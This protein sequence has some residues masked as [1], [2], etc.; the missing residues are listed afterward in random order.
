MATIRTAIAL[1]DGVTSP[2]HSMQ[3]AMNIVL[4]SFEAMQRASSNAVD[5]SAIQEARDELARAETAFDSIEQSIRDADNQQQKFNSSIRA[6]S[7]A[8]DGLWNKLKGIAATVGGLTAL[9]KLV[10]LSDSM[11]STKA[12]LN[13]IVDDGGSV[14]DLEKKIMASAQRSRASY[15]ST[16]KA[17][18]QMGLMAGDAF[19]NNDELIAF[20]ET[21]NK[22]FVIAG[23]NAAGAE[24]AT[25]QLTQAMASGVLRGEE[26]NSVFEQAPNVIQSIADYLDVP[27]GQIRTM[28]SEGQITADIVKNAMISATDEVNAKFESMPL[29]WGQV[30]TQAGNIALQVLQPL[31]NGIN[32]LANNISIIGPAVLGLAGAFAVFQI[33]AHWTQIA[34][35]ATAIYHGV[36]NFLSIGFGVLTGN[37]A[38]ASAAVFTFNSALLANP[39]VWVVMLIMALIGAL[40]AGVAAY[41]KFTGAGVSATGIIGG[42]FAVLG[43]FLINSFIVPLQNGFAMIANFLGNV[44]NNPIAAVKVAFYDMCLTVIGYITKLAHAIENLLNKI[45]GV[46]VDITSGLDNFYAGLEQ[47]QQKVKDESGWVEYVQ[48]MDFIDYSDAASAGYK[49]GE[50][51]ADKISGAFNLGG[52]EAFDLGNTLDGIYGNTGDTAN[53]T[54]ATADALD[55]NNEELK[56][57]REIAEREAIN[58]FTTAEIKVE[59]NNQN[60]I[61]GTEDLDGIISELE[62]KVEEAMIEASEGVHI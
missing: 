44:F 45:P 39:I 7:S 56:L 17:V 26:L 15:L 9:K 48:K 34:A 38:A 14:A 60:T 4:N 31:L 35:A 53:N 58:R 30:F 11:A 10:D 41:N 13:L 43:A 51:I 2:L 32:W 33:A 1:Y 25:L 47:A 6:G 46:T 52:V 62:K 16:A 5:V 57:L 27:I 29:T 20:T 49:F 21:L 24:A 55:M 36:V 50:G 8:A 59:M 54:A 18:S 19:A 22:Q 61:S 3:K 42:A 37:T 28:A 40:Y 12:R 23:A